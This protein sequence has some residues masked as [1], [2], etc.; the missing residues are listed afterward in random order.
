MAALVEATAGMILFTTPIERERERE[1]ERG[2]HHNN[3][4]LWQSNPV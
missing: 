1:R 3:C 4:I 2:E